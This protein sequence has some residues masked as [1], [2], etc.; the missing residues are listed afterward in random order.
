MKQGSRA[1]GPLLPRP[2]FKPVRP[3]PSR[4]PAPG[5]ARRCLPGFEGR[6]S[7]I[8]EPP[9]PLPSAAPPA[10][11]THLWH[12]RFAL[13]KPRAQSRKSRHT[14]TSAPRPALLGS[15][16]RHGP[17]RA[18]RRGDSAPCDSVPEEIHPSTRRACGCGPP[19]SRSAPSRAAGRGGLSPRQGSDTNLS[20]VTDLDLPGGRLTT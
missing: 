18:R 10:T 16:D 14:V 11:S 12:C 6:H 7:P 4:A 13:Q 2:H 5:R 9:A 19:L 1:P 20:G 15:A 3:L 8:A 17:Q